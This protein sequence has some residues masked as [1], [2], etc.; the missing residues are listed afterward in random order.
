MVGSKWREREERLSL[1]KPNAQG[2]GSQGLLTLAKCRV[3]GAFGKSGSEAAAL[4]IARLCTTMR[5][6]VS[7]SQ[8]AEPELFVRN[9]KD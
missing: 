9:V 8:T 4:H 1:A 7:P 5:D 2:W 3:V 6:L